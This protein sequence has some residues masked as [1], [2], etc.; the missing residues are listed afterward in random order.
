METGQQYL[1]VL[2]ASTVDDIK[3]LYPDFNIDNVQFVINNEDIQY[4]NQLVQMQSGQPQEQTYVLHQQ[5]APQVQHG[6]PQVVFQTQSVTEDN[7]Q[8]QPVS[9]P[10]KISSEKRRSNNVSHRFADILRAADA[11]R[12]GAGGIES[13]AGTTGGDQP[14]D[15]GAAAA[16]A[17]HQPATAA[18]PTDQLRAD[19]KPHPGARS[20]SDAA[21]PVAAADGHP[22]HPARPDSA[23]LRDDSA[24]ATAAVLHPTA[25]DANSHVRNES[26]G[27]ASAAVAAAHDCVAATAAAAHYSAAADPGAARLA[28]DPAAART[29]RAHGAAEHCPPESAAGPGDH[30]LDADQGGCT[31]SSESATSS[32]AT[33]CAPHDAADTPTAAESS[34]HASYV[35]ARAAVAATAH[36]AHHHPSAQRGPDAEPHCHRVAESHSKPRHSAASCS[37]GG[38]RQ[39]HLGVD[40][41]GANRAAAAAKHADGRQAAGGQEL[42][43]SG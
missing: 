22:H 23:V 36:R 5:E 28:P 20:D 38:R 8:E 30:H 1:Q 15:S 6:Q 13:A 42:G 27:S 37:T 33:L 7:V 10:P 9:F 3:Q 41:T 31:A 35:P 40:A 11:T 29:D 34:T 14:A 21:P 19:T 43:R 4:G 32:A 16:C 17:D 12:A 18:N 26:S 24:A 2:N 25:A 39:S